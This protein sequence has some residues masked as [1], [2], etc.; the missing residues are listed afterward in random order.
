MS[1]GLIYG[2]KNCSSTRGG[3]DLHK[4][5]GESVLKRTAITDVVCSTQT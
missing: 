2:K 3:N 5:D 1:M 4:A